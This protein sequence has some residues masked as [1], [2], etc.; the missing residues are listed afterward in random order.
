MSADPITAGIDLVS[1][2]VGKFVKDN[3]YKHI[4]QVKDWAL[5]G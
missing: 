5:L 4:T 2:F 1:T 3:I